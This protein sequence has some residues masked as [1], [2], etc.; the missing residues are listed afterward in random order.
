M[1]E[2][3]AE[4]VVV[5]LDRFRIDC[6]QEVVAG[7]V[8]A[9]CNVV[10]RWKRPILGSARM[11]SYLALVAMTLNWFGTAAG[12][13]VETR[14]TRRAEEAHAALSACSRYLEAWS[15]YLDPVT[16]LL[17]QRLGE[18]VWTPENSAADNFPYFFYIL[19]R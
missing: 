5:V 1:V 10:Q 3:T 15:R 9:K 19:S 2:I 7:M 14:L 17:P 16:G 13:S 12:E 8:T 18:R 11:G 6:Q 4:E